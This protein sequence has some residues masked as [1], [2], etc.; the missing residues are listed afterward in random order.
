MGLCNRSH[1]RQ[2]FQLRLKYNQG[3]GYCCTLC[4]EYTGDLATKFTLGTPFPS[5]LLPSYEFWLLSGIC[6]LP[7]SHVLPEGI[8]LA[9]K[10]R[11]CLDWY[12]LIMMATLFCQDWPTHGQAMFFWPIRLKGKSETSLVVQWLRLCASIAWH[13]FNPWSGN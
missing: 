13:K 6:P 7:G 1:H 9:P 4:R 5:P 10:P 11:W 2:T 12:E 3:H 8:V